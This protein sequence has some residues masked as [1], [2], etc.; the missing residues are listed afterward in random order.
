MFCDTLISPLT[1]VVR[2]S[3]WELFGPGVQRQRHNEI[4]Q[5][6]EPQSLQAVSSEV[7]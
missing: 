2:L 1:V 4:R 5:A 6:P 3:S 7:L